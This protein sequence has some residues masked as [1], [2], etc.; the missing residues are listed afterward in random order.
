[1][2][3]A[4]RF[5]AGGVVGT[6]LVKAVPADKAKMSGRLGKAR[7]PAAVTRARIV[8]VDGGENDLRS[9]YGWL[10]NEDDLRGCVR[11]SRPPIGDE[12]MG[13]G[14]D[15][16]MVALGSGGALTVLASAVP[17]WLRQ[18]RGSRVKV[19]VKMSPAGK[20]VIIEGPADAAERLLKQALGAGSDGP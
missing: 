2:V 3:G 20:T 8:I 10:R 16:I 15:A 19:E 6:G 5:L 12:E 17:T 9:L 11:L 14:P 1:M 4:S 13:T 18:R 7:M